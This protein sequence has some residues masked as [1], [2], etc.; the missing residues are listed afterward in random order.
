MPPSSP[1]EIVY[2]LRSSTNNDQISKLWSPLICSLFPFFSTVIGSFVVEFQLLTSSLY[3]RQSQTS[4]PSRRHLFTQATSLPDLRS[5]SIS[6]S[7]SFI[8]TALRLQICKVLPLEIETLQEIPAHDVT[9]PFDLQISNPRNHLCLCHA[10]IEGDPLRF[11]PPR[12]PR[13]AFSK[14]HARKQIVICGFCNS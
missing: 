13:L 3:V 7:L 11:P 8:N 9:Q 6:L 10:N 1:C 4:S 2:N 12:Q 5:L 14:D